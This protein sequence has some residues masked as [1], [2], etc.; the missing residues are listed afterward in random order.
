MKFL[1]SIYISLLILIPTIIVGQNSVPELENT[2]I[3]ILTCRSGDELYST[4]GHTAIRIVNSEDNFDI[5]YNYG[6]FSFNTPNFYPKFMRGKLPYYLGVT[7]TSNF[8]NEYTYDKRSVFEQEL[9]LNKEQK[10]SIIQFLIENAKPE[11]RAYKYDFFY[12]NCAT[13][14]VDVFSSVGEVTYSYAIDQ[15]TFRELLKENLRNLVWSDFGIDLVIGARA[16][17]YANR[18]GQMFLPEYVKVNLESATLD[19]AVPL[20]KPVYLVLDFEA[21]DAKRKKSGTNWPLICTSL[22]LILTLM[23][24]LANLKIARIYNKTILVVSSIV[25]LLLLFMWFGT[26]HGA[27]KDNWNILWMNPLILIY[28]FVK[29]KFKKGMIYIISAGL[30]IAGLNC[31]FNFLPQF[32]NLAF[33]PIILTLAVIFYKEYQRTNKSEVIALT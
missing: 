20:A 21:L 22:F 14:V 19:N 8:L 12:D 26:E 17:R 25:G 1:F 4:F 2:K 10:R 32:F 28:L 30:A 16:D 11:N 27:T 3:S 31:I 15:K 7:K 18:R 33:L 6:I 24:N 5:V 29:E 23:V 13:R 9:N